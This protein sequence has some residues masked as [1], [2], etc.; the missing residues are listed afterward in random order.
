MQPHKEEKH[1]HVPA[2]KDNRLQQEPELSEAWR[3][4][5]GLQST[6]APG[7]QDAPDPMAQVQP[8]ASD[9]WSNLIH[10]QGIESVDLQKIHL[11]GG[12]APHLDA[13]VEHALDIMQ[14]EPGRVLPIDEK[15]R[16]S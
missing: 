1:N 7:N 11:H 2:D 4:L 14:E 15:P 3:A 10:A 13:E 6:D 9:P 8:L 5:L 12:R 16:N